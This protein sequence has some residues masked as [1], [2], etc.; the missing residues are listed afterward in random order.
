[1]LLCQVS[2]ALS[3]ESKAC[4][5]AHS[6]R[7]RVM[8]RLPKLAVFDLGEGPGWGKFRKAQYFSKAQ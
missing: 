7:A 1:M 2:A 5:R 6:L 8:A 4:L 3:C